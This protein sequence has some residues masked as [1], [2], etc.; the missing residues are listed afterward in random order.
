MNEID[1]PSLPSEP[2]DLAKEE[3]SSLLARSGRETVAGLW[4]T[5]QSEMMDLASVIRTES[6]LKEMAGKLADLRDRY[7]R[8]SIGDRGRLFNTD[9]L[10]AIEFGHMLDVSETIVVSALARQESRGA[11]YREDF[12]QRDDPNWLKHTFVRRVGGKLELS[13]KPVTITRFPPQERKY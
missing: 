8:I 4:S 9:L 1:F 2:D 13:Y 10:E 12:P 11:H 7:G 3:I 5:L 6:A